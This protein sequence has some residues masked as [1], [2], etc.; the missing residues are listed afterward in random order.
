[1]LG[2]YKL[3]EVYY[4]MNELQTPEIFEINAATRPGKGLVGLIGFL[5]NQGK[6]RDFMVSEIILN[7]RENI[8][9]NKTNYGPNEDS[10]HK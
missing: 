10:Y 9:P 8:S 1:M 4:S 6:S 7:E 5:M 2:L 3:S